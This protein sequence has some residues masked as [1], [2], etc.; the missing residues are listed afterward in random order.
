MLGQYRP[1]R[2]MLVCDDVD[3][4]ELAQSGHL[5]R[6]LRLAVQAGLAP[7]YAIYL[8]SLGCAEYW[9]LRHH[10]AIAPGYL[11]DLVLFEDLTDF[12]ARWTMLGGQIVARDG[13]MLGPLAATPRWPQLLDTVHLPPSWNASHLR[14]VADKTLPVIGVSGEQITTERLE[15][16]LMPQDG[17]FVADPSEDLI[18]LALVERHSGSGRTG[19]ALARGFGLQAGAFGQTISHDAHNIIL[20]GVND[21]DMALVAEELQRLGG[22]VVVVD[23]GVVLARLPLPL[24]GL[25]SDDD[26][27]V[28]VQQQQAIEAA[29][30]GLGCTLPHPVMTLSFLALTVIPKLKVTDQ[31]LFDVEQFALL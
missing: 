2:A 8:A 13:Q 27:A 31:G 5:N 29:L 20:A 10:G 25:V 18:K 23:K 22:G 14:F 4:L 7:E 9:G 6:V 30:H 16:A 3:A 12:R 17:L 19:L 1:Q 11:A 21:D 28:V 26:P 15:L 24:A